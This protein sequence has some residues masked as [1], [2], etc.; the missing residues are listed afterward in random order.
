MILNGDGRTKRRH[1]VVAARLA[2]RPFVVSIALDHKGIPGAALPFDGVRVCNLAVP[3]LMVLL[4][5]GPI[6]FL[7]IAVQIEAP[8]LADLKRSQQV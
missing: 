4:L 6:V 3:A 1:I 8:G 5:I 7:D 2:P